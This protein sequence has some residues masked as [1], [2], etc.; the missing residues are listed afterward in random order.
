MD[1]R[2]QFTCVKEESLVI[3][4]HQAAV[5]SNID[6]VLI[7]RHCLEDASI[8][9]VLTNQSNYGLGVNG[10]PTYVDWAEVAT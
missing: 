8:K 7:V 10:V 2:L 9:V 6:G 4:D 5:N 1:H 3:A